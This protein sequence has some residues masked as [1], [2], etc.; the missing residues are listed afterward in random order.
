MLTEV[1]SD[2]PTS[3][4]DIRSYYAY[5]IEGFVLLSFNGVL[6]TAIFATRGLRSQKEY[7]IFATNLLL[8]AIFGLTYFSAGLYRLFF[9]YYKEECKF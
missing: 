6:A 7:I 2:A 5:V 9:I 4:M 3:G 8:D 1:Y